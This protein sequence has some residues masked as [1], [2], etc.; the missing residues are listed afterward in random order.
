MLVSTTKPEG[1][2]M[3]R[4]ARLRIAVTTLGALSIAGT[5]AG[6]S[7]ATGASTGSAD[8]SGD[9]ATTAP[10]NGGAE[11]AGSYRDGEYTA[12]GGYQSPNGNESITVDLTLHGGVVSAVKVTGD[13]SGPDAANY[14]SQFES[15][16]GALVVGKS[17]DELD[18]TKVAGSSLTSAGFD[19]AVDDI[20]SQAAA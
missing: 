12:H 13:P 19:A 15:G 20:K 2:V 5:I 7:T 8:T 10:S 14:Q 1:L 11:S 16:I 3:T 4:S 6:C 17:I 9:V 18:V